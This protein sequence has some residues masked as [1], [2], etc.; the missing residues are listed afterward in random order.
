MPYRSISCAEQRS[1]DV[2]NQPFSTTVIATVTG[3]LFA[4]VGC[5][6]MPMNTVF[7]PPPGAGVVMSA[8]GTV[9]VLAGVTLTVLGIRMHRARTLLALD[10]NELTVTVRAGSVPLRRH[11]I[12]LE[13]IDRVGVEMSEMVTYRAQIFLRNGRAIAIGDAT[14]SAR[15][16]YERVVSQIRSF[17]AGE[18]SR[19]ST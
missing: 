8:V 5:L 7:E 16:H 18:A 11:V 6:L 4:A 10:R 13:D 9:L 14:T 1:L 3:I 12:R 17:L 2:R 19:G 15:G